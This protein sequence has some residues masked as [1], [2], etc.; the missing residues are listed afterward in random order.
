MD[1]D[2]GDVSIAMR[3]VLRKQ[4][5]KKFNP[6][7]AASMLFLN[8]TNPNTIKIART[9]MIEWG[10]RAQ[11]L[12]YRAAKM[13]GLAQRQTRRPPATV[14]RPKLQAQV[15]HFINKPMPGKLPKRTARAL[16][17]HR[18]P[19]HRARSSAIRPR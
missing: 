2:F 11:R 4:G 5:K 13:L 3:N 18:G 7:T 17:E 9:L 1:I 15:V 16:L 14:G 8:A 6:G 19:P 12:A 10:Y